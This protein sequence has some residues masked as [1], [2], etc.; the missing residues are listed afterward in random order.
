MKP[1]PHPNEDESHLEEDRAVADPLADETILLWENT[2]RKNR[3]IFTEFFRPVPTNLV[4]TK[5][6]Y[7]VCHDPR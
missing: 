2:A 1:A 3:E 7:K 4:R 5:S 6:A